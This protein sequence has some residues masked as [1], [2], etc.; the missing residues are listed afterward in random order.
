MT[1]PS[2]PNC[3]STPTNEIPMFAPLLDRIDDL[4][5]VVVT[6]GQLQTQ[7]GH[8]TACATAARTTCSPRR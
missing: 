5:E 6:A 2:P 4:T 8:A 7:R 1:A 3:P